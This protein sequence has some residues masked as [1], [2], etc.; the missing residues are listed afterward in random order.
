[1]GTSYYHMFNI[2]PFFIN[3]YPNNHFT[4]NAKLQKTTFINSF[5]Y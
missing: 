2:T 5:S 4:L 3:Q 1:M